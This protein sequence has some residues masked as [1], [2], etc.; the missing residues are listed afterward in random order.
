MISQE[1]HFT[2]FYYVSK[3]LERLIFDK[4]AN[5]IYSR[6]FVTQFR[7]TSHKAPVRKLLITLNEA[8]S[9]INSKRCPDVIDPLRFKDSL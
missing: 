9:S 7:F 8:V 2:A 6:L 1:T 5:Y 4:L 3:V